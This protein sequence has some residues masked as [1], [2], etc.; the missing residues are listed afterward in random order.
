MELSLHMNFYLKRS[1]EGY[2]VG[3]IVGILAKIVETLAPQS[4]H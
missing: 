1:V 4:C 2:M 3:T